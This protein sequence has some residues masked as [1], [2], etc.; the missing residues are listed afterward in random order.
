LEGRGRE[1]HGRGIRDSRRLNTAAAKVSWTDGGGAGARRRSAAT[2]KTA[3]PLA[4][5]A[6]VGLLGRAATGGPPPFAGGKPTS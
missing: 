6:A 5:P 4:R 2:W 3:A 1:A